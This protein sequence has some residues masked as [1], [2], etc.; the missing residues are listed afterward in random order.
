MSVDDTD[1]KILEILKDDSR[2]HGTVISRSVGIPVSTVYFRIRSM[3]ATGV[4]KRF[5][6]ETEDIDEPDELTAEAL[7]RLIEAHKAQAAEYRKE[8][9]LVWS[10]L[11]ACA[12][13]MRS[14]EEEGK[15]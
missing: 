8:T 15:R 4:I 1:R 12:R 13:R 2:T 9:D 7:D 10:A 11:K 3:L 14:L 6:I 5:T